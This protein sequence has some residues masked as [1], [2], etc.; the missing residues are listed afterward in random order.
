[1]E[2]TQCKKEQPFIIDISDINQET[3]STTIDIQS[4]ISS[5][6]QSKC[7]HQRIALLKSILNYF[8]KSFT[9]PEMFKIT[10]NIMND[11]LLNSFKH[12]ISNVQY[13]GSSLFHLTIHIIISFICQNPLKLSL[14]QNNG[15]ADI[16]M[17]VL[18]KKDLPI[19]KD[20]IESLPNIFSGLCLNKHGLDNFIK[21]KPFDKL[22]EIFLLPKY[23]PIMIKLHDNNTSLIFRGI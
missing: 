13:Y 5:I 4:P 16:L 7:Y 11:S 9:E 10:H 6:S 22:F 2:I 21:F 18:L 1:Y 19:S 12:I 8:K 15:L 17:Y 23:L 14:L 20:I 3:T